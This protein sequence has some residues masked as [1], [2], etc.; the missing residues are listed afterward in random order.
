MHQGW[1][2]EKTEK[3][4]YVLKLIED[5]YYIG[6]S[7]DPKK[8]IRKQFRG[9]GSAWTKQFPPIEVLLIESIGSMDYKEAE[10]YENRMVLKYMKQF[11]WENV[12]G[13]FFTN[14][15]CEIVYKNLLNHKSKGTFEIDFL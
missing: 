5:K 3:F 8:R 14:V 4:L 10:A 7:T 12:R 2:K 11:G 13:G 1:M 15:D 9:S 6:Q